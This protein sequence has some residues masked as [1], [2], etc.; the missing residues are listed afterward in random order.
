MGPLYDQ[1]RETLTA[2]QV[3]ASLR[4]QIMDVVDQIRWIPDFGYERELD[5]LRN[6]HD[7]MI[8]KKRYW[9]LALPIYDCAACGTIE[10]IGGRD[11]LHDRAVEGWEA[12]EGHTPHRPYVDAVKIACP[13]CGAPV[14]RIKDVGNPWL[15]AGIVPFSTLHYREDPEYWQQ[16]FP[17]DFIT[18]S[19]PGQFRNWFYSM[20]AMSTV[21]RREPP[22]E[23]IFGYALVFAEDGR[24]MHKSWGNA[25]EFDEAADRMGVDVMRW[26]FAKARPEENITFGWHAADEARRELLILWNVYA[27]FVT[28]A[29][30]AGWSPLE[31][32]PP[33]ADRPLLDR[34]ILSRAAATSAAVEERLLDVDALGATRALSAYLDGLSTW[35]LRL[36]RRRFS[37]SDDPRDQDAAFATLHEALVAS[38]RMLAP[39][40]PFLADALYGNLVTTVQP[41]EPDSVH[42]TPWP[43]AELARHRDDELEASMAIAQGAVD[44]VRGLRSTAHIRNRQPLATAWLA[45]P[46]RGL[47]ID[48]DLLDLIAD[49]VNVKE[50]VVIA[51]D[52]ALVE[53]RVKPLLPRIGKRLGSAI[54]AVMAAARAGEVT[55][56]SDGSV[57][58][59]GVT[60][61][62]DEV[63]IQ[64]TPRPGTAVAHHD[65]LV[66]V[67]DTALTPELVAEGDARELARAVQ[68]L[69]REAGLELD[70]RIDLWVRDLPAAVAP[71]L[72]GVATDTLADLAAGDAPADAP[73]ATV[74]LAG[75][76]VVIALRRRVA[77]RTPA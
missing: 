55:F 20:L 41:D 18:E 66:V 59:A 32:P 60:L 39:I 15:D 31:A 77:D 26:M 4:Y 40:L 48:R 29:R 33:V 38:A 36:S 54:P 23:T 22:F 19:F 21:L 47:A 6:M 62:P 43:S 27:F 74:E 73:T 72:A 10:V 17:A 14:E 12:F 76:P 9:G 70:D 25:I 13:S 49:E 37:R 69:R 45:L 53:R 2:E 34:W 61:A 57:T 3:D 35:Y 71:H 11:E 24:Q 8:S 1:P 75:G 44:L 65:G 50:V 5:W 52:S 51:D 7:W 56:E 16:W 42:L 46:D 67:L 63:E 68:D 64:A 30:L 58:L 28:Y